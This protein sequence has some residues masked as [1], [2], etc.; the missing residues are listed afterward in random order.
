VVRP[1][2]QR[3][4]HAHRRLLACLSERAAQGTA[5]WLPWMIVTGIVGVL[6]AVSGFVFEYYIGPEKH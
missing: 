5:L 1:Q 4:D 6:A 3:A 2:A